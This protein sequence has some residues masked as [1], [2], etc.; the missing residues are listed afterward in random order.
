MPLGQKPKQKQN[1]NRFN[2]DFK[3]WSA[4]HTQIY[5]YLYIYIH[6]CV[7]IHIYSLKSL[8]Q[9]PRP[10]VVW[11]LPTH[12][13]SVLPLTL[14]P[15]AE[16]HGSSSSEGLESH[17]AFPPGPRHSFSSSQ[18]CGLLTSMPQSYPGYCPLQTRLRTHP[19]P[20][21]Q[22]STRGY[23]GVMRGSSEWSPQL[24]SLSDLLISVIPI[25]S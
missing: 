22:K 7:Y 9:L 15:A 19:P 21:G 23:R 2:K 6:V 17:L 24:Q 8:R 13:T 25:N 10:S 20:R 5:V 16:S 4:S 14:P 3:N 18:Q 12:S 11:S 1:C